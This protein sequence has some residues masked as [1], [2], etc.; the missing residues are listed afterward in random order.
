MSGAARIALVTCALGACG[1]EPLHAVTGD[2]CEERPEQAACALPS[3][4][5]RYSRANSDAWLSAHHD[6][7][8][9]MHPRVL[10][11]DFHN[12][13]SAEQVRRVAQRQIDALAEGSRYHG[14]SDPAAPAFLKYE[15]LEMIDLKDNPLPRDWPHTSSS[16][17][18]L[19]EQGRFDMKALF[20]D[21]FTRIYD[22]RDENGE[23]IDLCGLFER[24]LIN[25]LWLAVGDA[26]REPPS[27]VE[28]KSVYDAERK[29]IE[30]K[31]ASTAA[32]REACAD[33]PACRASVRIAHLSPLRG[34]GC[35]LQVRG[36]AIQG[37]LRAIP[38]LETNA[39]AFMEDCG[40]PDL[41]PNSVQDYDYENRTVVQARCVN[42][43]LR[44]GS[45]G[46]DRLAPYS[47]DTVAGLASRYP[48]CGG[49]WQIYWR[50]S[51]PGLDNP[52][53]AMDG[54]PMKNWWPFLFY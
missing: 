22:R 31:R 54:T 14:Y 11:L 26:E 40:E 12:G 34:V 29:R 53:K 48:D 10:V 44:N 45:N 3:W 13:Q 28:C 23:L 5:N 17:V 41:A 46:S 51:M 25:E 49:W 52:A 8:R 15:L 37:S 21:A 20:S 9:E 1:T 6:A 42:Y 50:Q 2:S 33:F 43:G 27:M 24:G 19:N 7:L 4:P 35:D 36:W 16:R 30:G 32:Y 47:F 39:R 38:Y 18:P